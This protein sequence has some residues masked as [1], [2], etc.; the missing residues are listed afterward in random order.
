MPAP[1]VYGSEL[2]P[3][4]LT[5]R[6]HKVADG[7]GHL[8]DHYD[9]ISYEAPT[10]VALEEL[11]AKKLDAYKDFLVN[12]I[13]ADSA[14]GNTELITMLEERHGVAAKT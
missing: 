13:S 9:V 12:A 6:L 2:G 1:L 5:V 7:A 8:S 11:T 10:T 3:I 14:I 4:R